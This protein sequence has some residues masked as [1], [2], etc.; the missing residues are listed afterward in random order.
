MDLSSLRHETYENVIS[1][2]PIRALSAKMVTRNQYKS[3]MIDV[4]HY[5]C[6]SAQ[7]IS[8]AGSRLVSSHRNMAAYLF[9]HAQ[10]ELG[11]E[12]WALS[13]LRELGMSDEEI[14]CSR[15]SAACKKMLG[16]EYL[17]AAHL[18]AVGLF[19]WMFALESL[20][21]KA[22][23]GIAKQID[24]CLELNGKAIYFLSGHGKADAVHSNDLER[25][26]A[27]EI[28]SDKDQMIFIEMCK[29]S[30][31][32]YIEI[33]DTAFRSSAFLESPQQSC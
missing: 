9:E 3:Y 29:M 5:A 15:P 27:T 23:S 4:Y 28:K 20:G 6:H 1:S 32:L 24:H 16:L 31:A 13:D 12:Q 14:S 19:G 25:V 33:L 7:V 8:I 11:H 10:E 2:A 21:G 26:I 30:T 18:D 17:Y 22:A